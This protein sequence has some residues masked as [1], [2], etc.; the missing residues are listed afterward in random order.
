MGGE[1]QQLDEAEQDD[2][3][4]GLQEH[5]IGLRRLDDEFFPHAGD[6]HDD[7]HEHFEAGMPEGAA[8]PL[9]L[10]GDFPLFSRMTI[11]LLWSF[12]EKHE[13]TFAVMLKEFEC[14]HPRS[15]WSSDLGM[16]RTVKIAVP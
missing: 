13:Y 6:D 14:G 2:G 16:V 8:E 12:F 15:A 11:L 4:V 10:H 5:G 7:S 1:L 9:Q 3:V